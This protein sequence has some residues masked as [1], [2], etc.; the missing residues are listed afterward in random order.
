MN[1]PTPFDSDTESVF[2]RG[3]QGKLFLLPVL[4]LPFAVVIGIWAQLGEA[5]LV[6][7]ALLACLAAAIAAWTV[8]SG[9]SFVAMSPSGVHYRN[10]L[11]TR[12]LPLADV[13]GF[14]VATTAV[15]PCAGLRLVTGELVPLVATL[16][17]WV[18]PEWLARGW[19]AQLQ[20][21]LSELR[22][23]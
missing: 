8:V 11:R 2:V 9:M 23:R 22:G 1:N 17:A 4:L 12:S 19:C 15:G 21:A 6:F 16:G 13:V 14:E 7:P 5:G 3:P 20:A 18:S 10:S